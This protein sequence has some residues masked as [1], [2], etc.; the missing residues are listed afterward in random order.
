VIIC[1]ASESWRPGG[2]AYTASKQAIKGIVDA[3]AMDYGP[4]G[5]RVN[6]IAP[7]TT[8]TPFVRPTGPAGRR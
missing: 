2:A 1:T 6:A 4:R 5:I 8:D 3:A 7:G